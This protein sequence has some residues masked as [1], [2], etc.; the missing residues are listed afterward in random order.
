M[1]EVKELRYGA[2]C[3]TDE[4]G[5][6]LDGA[7]VMGVMG[8]VGSVCEIREPSSDEDEFAVEIEDNVRSDE[9]DEAE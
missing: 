1:F 3:M 5:S 7:G 6:A 9:E 8:V 2:G 4:G